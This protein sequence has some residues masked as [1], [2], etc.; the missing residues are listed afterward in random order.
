MTTTNDIPKAI[1]G[2]DFVDLRFTDLKDKLQHVTLDGSL[3][4]DWSGQMAAPHKMRN[5]NYYRK[6][7]NYYR[8]RQQPGI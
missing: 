1:K 6:N 8:S 2:I 3:V 4:D 7:Y 5:H